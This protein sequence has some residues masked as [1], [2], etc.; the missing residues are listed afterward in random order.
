ME[1][2]Q[3]VIDEAAKGGDFYLLM[4]DF[5][6]EFYRSVPAVRQGMIDVAPA[7][8]SGVSPEK[9][10]YAAATAHKLANDYQLTVPSWVFESKYYLR[11]KPYFAGNV[12]G[13]LR[14]LL[15]YFSPPEFKHRN[16]FVDANALVRV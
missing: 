4:G 16:L 10:A 2:L 14:L 6:D 13:K 15:L 11:E 7:S 3:Q 8:S 5:L 1:H 12:E 9:L